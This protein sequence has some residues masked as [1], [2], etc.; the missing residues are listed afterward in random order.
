M[1]K[2]TT[3]KDY[4]NQNIKVEKTMRAREGELIETKDEIIFDVKGL[5]HPP[6]KIIAFPRFIPSTKGNRIRK[7]I[8]YGKIYNL[9][10]RFDFLRNKFP[11]LI[12]YDPVFDETL[13]EIP[14]DLIK[15]SGYFF[16]FKPFEE[17]AAC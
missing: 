11:N 9:K 16:R 4:L 7:E 6:K 5:I 14:D 17:S 3:I 8:K 10:E 13:C 15:P 2:S 1:Q 12:A